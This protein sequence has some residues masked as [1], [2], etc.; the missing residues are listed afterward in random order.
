MPRGSAVGAGASVWSRLAAVGAATVI[1]ASALAA[2]PVVAAGTPSA[3]DPSAP[4]AKA[5]S[6]SG[7]VEAA[8]PVPIRDG[9]RAGGAAGAA[10]TSVGLRP[11]HLA[12]APAG[13]SRPSSGRAE[14]AS[15]RDAHSRTYMN[16]DGSVTQEVSSG[17]M[18]YKDGQGHWQPLD[19]S[20]VPET[21]QGALG[22]KV[23]ASNAA[24]RVGSGLGSAGIA[25]YTDPTG[26]YSVTLYAAG[27]G[28]ASFDKPNNRADFAPQAGGEVQVT[29][30]PT[31]TGFE[32]GATFPDAKASP[33]VTL[34]ISAPGL[35]P[36]VDSATGAVML[37]DSSGTSRIEITA[38]VVADA[39]LP[40]PAGTVT[41]AI[42][43]N[44]AVGHR[45]LRYGIDPAYLT[46]PARVFPV[47]LD[48]GVGSVCTRLGGT[49]GCLDSTHYFDTYIATTR[50]ARTR[51]R[52]RWTVSATTPTA[53]PP[54][55]APTGATCAPCSGSTRP[56]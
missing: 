43:G 56:P 15:L 53:C 49:N 38:P 42:I 10:D 22:L 26:A 37:Q 11:A 1:L 40:A 51:P 4:S 19:L 31:D 34:A 36:V 50:R 33:T 5:G 30:Q 32:F 46:D 20:L 29:A 18:N 8:T 54:T 7:S 17:R 24:V 55:P 14:I 13:V 9:S 52:R 3:N 47:T 48:P 44:D 23:A 35:S 39:G 21:G 2:A 28:P 41:T 16:A 6:S 12:P 25:S 45:M 27:F